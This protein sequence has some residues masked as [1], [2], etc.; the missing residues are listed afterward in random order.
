[1]GSS[2]LSAIASKGG[3]RRRSGR[4]VLMAAALLGSV[5]VVALYSFFV[6]ALH[7]RR[8]GRRERTGPSASA[9]AFDA[10]SDTLA[11]KPMYRDAFRRRRC[12]I[13]MSGFH[14]WRQMEDG[15]Q[16]FFISGH[17]WISSPSGVGKTLLTR[18]NALEGRSSRA[19]ATSTSWA[20]QL[21]ARRGRFRTWPTNLAVLS[22]GSASVEIC[23]LEAGL[24]VAITFLYA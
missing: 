18:T 7:L 10:R 14:E 12:V 2:R 22:G 4:I 23:A 13:P 1:M 11:S 6:G 19:R 3:P 17:C 16:P 24:T 20:A 8:D 5:P 15:K 21:A 9:P